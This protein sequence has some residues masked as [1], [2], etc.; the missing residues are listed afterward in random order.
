[1]KLSHKQGEHVA[2]HVFIMLTS[3]SHACS[4][5]HTQVRFIRLKRA[6]SDL[7]PSNKQTSQ[8][9][10]ITGVKQLFL[11]FNVFVITFQINPNSQNLI[12]MNSFKMNVFH[13]YMK[14]TMWASLCRKQ[15]KCCFAVIC[16]VTMLTELWP[17]TFNLLHYSIA[18][19]VVTLYVSWI[20]KV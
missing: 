4:P 17:L 12:I 8:K 13:S 2:L 15:P 16:S 14:A 1:M 5:S 6:I 19:G 9:W 20:Y 7:K 3:R 18:D 10:F 11:R